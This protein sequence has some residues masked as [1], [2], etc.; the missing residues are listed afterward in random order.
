MHKHVERKKI[1]NKPLTIIVLIL[2]AIMLF[3]IWLAR[4][5]DSTFKNRLLSAM[6]LPLSLVENRLIYS[7]EFFSRLQSHNA[8]LTKNGQS[9]KEIKTRIKQRLLYE[10]KM[11][12]LAIRQKAILVNWQNLVSLP[13]PDV[14]KNLLL[15]RAVESESR[16]DALKFWFYSQKSLN[17]N[18]YKNADFILKELKHGKSFGGLAQIYSQDITSMQLEGDLGPVLAENLL[19]EFKEK[20]LQSKSGDILVLPSRLGLHV[21]NVYLRKTQGEGKDVLYLKQI[22]LKGGEF[23]DWVEVET[24]DY[25]LVNIIKI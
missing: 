15:K 20:L 22:Y 10:K 5:E 14:E 16:E 25:K 4:S 12:I 23:K 8:I 19:F 18:A 24:K 3:F 13:W 21:I 6:P 11:E 7:N 2:S 17:E 1:E 9:M